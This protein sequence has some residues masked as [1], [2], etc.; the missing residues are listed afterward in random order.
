MTAREVDF[1]KLWET[2]CHDP[3]LPV[4]NLD[5]NPFAT[6]ATMIPKEVADCAALIAKI[7][8][9]M[10]AKL[11]LHKD[12]I[13]FCPMHDGTYFPVM[14]DP[15]KLCKHRIRR[16]FASLSRRYLR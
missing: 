8:K 1:N 3:E 16:N 11:D 10:Q 5:D 7:G 14:A 4:H 12:N 6:V 15:L 9:R 13:M 2:N